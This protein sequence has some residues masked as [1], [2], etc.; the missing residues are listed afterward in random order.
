[1]K[2]QWP[3]LLRS[4]ISYRSQNMP[5]FP[6]LLPQEHLQLRGVRSVIFVLNWSRR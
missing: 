2:L 4:R 1:M 5:L 6:R 3:L